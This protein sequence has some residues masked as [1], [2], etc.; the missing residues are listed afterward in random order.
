MHQ[1]IC[2]FYVPELGAE[3]GCVHP[4]EYVADWLAALEAKRAADLR[5]E[6]GASEAYELAAD[7]AMPRLI[8]IARAAQALDTAY[9]ITALRATKDG[10]Y[11]RIDI[12][13]ELWDAFMLSLEGK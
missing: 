2:T 9:K 1:G 10:N 12:R 4:Q 11:W 5:G 7:A 13:C 3:C 6:A 8:E